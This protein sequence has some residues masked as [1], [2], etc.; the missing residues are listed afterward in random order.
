MLR[1]GFLFMIAYLLLVG[2]GT[3]DSPTATPE[4]EAEPTEDAASETLEPTAVPPTET[5]EPTETTVPASP[6]PGLT[7]VL[8]YSAYIGGLPDLQW[9]QQNAEA[10]A[11]ER[12]DLELIFNSGN[13]YTGPVNRAIHNEIT[14]DEPPD[15]MSGLVVGVLREY[16]AQGLIADISDIW[17]EQGWDEVF[18]ASLKEM[19]TINGKQYFV[20]TAIQWNGIYYRKDVFEAV[21]LTPPE[22]WEEL[23]AVCDTLRAAEY[24]PFT[25]VGGQWPPPMGFWFT[26]INLRLNGPEFH[27]RLMLGQERYNGPEVRAVFEHLRQMFEHECFET[28]TAS[29]TYDRAITQFESGEIGM[30]N[31]G[32]WLYEF[33]DD[34]TKAQTG[35]FPYPVI[36]PEVSNGELVPMFGAFIHAGAE[37][38][39]EAREFLIYLAGQESQQSNAESLNRVASNLLVDQSLYDEVHAQGVALVEQAGHIT[40]LYGAN[41]QPTVTAR[42]YQLIAQ[43]WQSPDDDEVLDLVL[44]EWEKVR[45]ETYGPIGNN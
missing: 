3:A 35:F 17:E 16:V 25:I 36:N 7:G 43:F 6:T 32:E 39:A 5:P 23:L 42:G 20:P 1:K 27:E 22:T 14:G 31:H 26:A 4:P 45:E 29:Y 11:A 41:T 38:V 13:Y 9:T 37:N 33:I 19:V 2:C 8:K 21:G 10:Y 30:Y 34:E 12:S 44:S 24:T 18:P 28:S 40:Q 15:V